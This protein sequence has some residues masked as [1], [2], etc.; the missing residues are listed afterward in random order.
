MH[1][2]CA[3]VAEATMASALR[4][5][6]LDAGLVVSELQLFSCLPN[7]PDTCRGGW[8]VVDAMKALSGVKVLESRSCKPL[9]TETFQS[10]RGEPLKSVVFPNTHASHLLQFCINQLTHGIKQ[11]VFCCKTAVACAPACTTDHP[12]E[13]Y[14][15]I[16][17]S[18]F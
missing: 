18:A 11:Q 4:V 14:E 1:R 15:A 16:E 8:K 2:V 7:S 9:N 13:R 17:C 6:A 12:F 5:S 10:A 3:A